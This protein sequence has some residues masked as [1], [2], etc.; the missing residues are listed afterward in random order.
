M[1]QKNY[2]EK[3]IGLKELLENPK[4]IFLADGTEMLSNS[5]NALA[6]IYQKNEEERE[7]D[8][9]QFSAWIQCLDSGSSDAWYAVVEDLDNDA[10]VEDLKKLFEYETVGEYG[11]VF[12]DVY[13]LSEEQNLNMSP[14]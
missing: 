13:G 3:F 10:N 5:S 14:N 9:L 2:H 11:K 12:K 7:S 6:V 1:S 4:V 8:E